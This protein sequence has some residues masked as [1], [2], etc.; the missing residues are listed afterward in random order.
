MVEIPVGR[1]EIRIQQ[2]IT[3]YTVFPG[4]A[5]E[6]LIF[7]L[8]PFYSFAGEKMDLQNTLFGSHFL[9]ASLWC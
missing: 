7:R 8:P 3:A 6:L 9:D 5:G 4:N 2:N 1:N